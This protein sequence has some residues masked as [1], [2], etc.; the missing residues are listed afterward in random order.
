MHSRKVDQVEAVKEG[1]RMT[2][3]EQRRLWRE[4]M[5]HRATAGCDKA[6]VA[7][8]REQQQAEEDMAAEWDEADTAAAALAEKG[9][10]G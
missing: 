1:D 5:G 9:L 3:E 7:V 8:R 4:A 2:E 10:V 6:A